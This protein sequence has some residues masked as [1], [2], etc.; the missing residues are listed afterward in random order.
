VLKQKQVM[1]KAPRSKR[2]HCKNT[3]QALLQQVIPE[4]T[5]DFN[6][7]SRKL[8][9]NFF[10]GSKGRSASNVWARSISSIVYCTGLPPLSMN[11]RREA[12]KVADWDSET[13]QIS[14][15]EG[16]EA[17]PTHFAQPHLICAERLQLLQRYKLEKKFQVKS[18]S[19]LLPDTASPAFSGRR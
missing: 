7:S 10:R 16:C 6:C 4:H 14:I 18:P 17:H 13:A 3:Q 8:S 11:C 12:G 1:S 5:D 9:L 2:N 19:G 15:I